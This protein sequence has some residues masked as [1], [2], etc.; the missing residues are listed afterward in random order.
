MEP[1]MARHAKATDAETVRDPAPPDAMSAA[2]TFAN[3]AMTASRDMLQFIEQSQQTRT[4]IVSD[5]VK[6]LGTAIGD[7]AAARDVQELMAIQSRLTN[8]QL[9]QA[10]KH[11]GELFNRMLVARARLL[12]QM[13]GSGGEAAWTQVMQQWVDTL[14][15]G[16][17]PS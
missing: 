8:E 10:M 7:A 2:R 17:I 5:M 4:A 16:P 9:A 12:A 14:R 11:N 3:V 13:P 1:I 15:N 6:A